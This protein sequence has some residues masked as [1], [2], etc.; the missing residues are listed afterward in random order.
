[1]EWHKASKARISSHGVD[2]VM[3]WANQ[4]HGDV[5][6]QMFTSK[7]DTRET[8]ATKQA[9]GPKD[10]QAQTHRG[11]KACKSLDLVKQTWI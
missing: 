9:G 8:D 3:H 10:Q 6:S 5:F 4:N 2:K 1:M 11:N 7:Q